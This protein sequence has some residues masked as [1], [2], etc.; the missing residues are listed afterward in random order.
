MSNELTCWDE[1]YIEE[2]NILSMVTVTFVIV[3]CFAPKNR[4]ITSVLTVP[5][6]VISSD[7]FQRNYS[8]VYK[9]TNEDRIELILSLVILTYLL[10]PKISGEK[11]QTREKNLVRD[12]GKV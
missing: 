7:A 9:F 8:H 10:Y 12:P 5:F 4:V 6:A 1:A 3:A 11:K 2:K